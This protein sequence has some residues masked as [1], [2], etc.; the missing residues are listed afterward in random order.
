M[1]PGTAKPD[2]TVVV[3]PKSNRCSTRT[4]DRDLD[5]ARHLIENLPAR[6]RQFHA[7]AACYDKTAHNLLAAIHINAG[8][9]WLS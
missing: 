4:Y 5:K 8:V 7:I 2:R 6:P 9:V 3:L 1:C